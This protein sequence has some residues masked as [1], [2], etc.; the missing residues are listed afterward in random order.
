MP[1]ATTSVLKMP[2]AVI[3]PKSGTN[4]PKSPL[5]GT[6]TQYIVKTVM[7]VIPGVT[8]HQAT[9]TATAI[10]IYEPEFSKA[11]EWA[12]ARV[13]IIITTAAAISRMGLLRILVLC[14]ARNTST[15]DAIRAASIPLSQ[16]GRSDLKRSVV[17]AGPTWP[18]IV[19]IRKTA[20][21][22]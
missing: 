20:R 5:T 2:V 9:A 10:A 17:S 18:E 22:G 15:R 7:P 19:Q 16:P 4:L 14:P 6:V 13:R 3:L 12:I 11:P 1:H 8:K 21:K